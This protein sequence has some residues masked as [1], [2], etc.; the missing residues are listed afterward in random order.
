MQFVT[1]TLRDGTEKRISRFVPQ[2]KAHNECILA[3]EQCFTQTEP[4]TCRKYYFPNSGTIKFNQ[5]R[6]QSPSGIR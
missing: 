1:H 5:E 3:N 2:N 6:L 4:Q